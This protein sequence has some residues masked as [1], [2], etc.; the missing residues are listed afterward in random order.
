ML[1]GAVD[2]AEG[3]LAL[4]CLL[5]ALHLSVRLWPAWPDEAVLDPMRLEE[6][7]ERAVVAVDEGVAES[8]LFGS[9]PCSARCASARSTKPVTVSARSSRCSS[10]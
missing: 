1:A 4:E 5:V 8:S 3:P 2:A 7:A 9:I 10:L 6:L